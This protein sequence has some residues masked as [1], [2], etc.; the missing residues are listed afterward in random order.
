MVRLLTR[1]VLLQIEIKIKQL[2]LNF[3]HWE[4]EGKEAEISGQEELKKRSA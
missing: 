2:V 4:K 1:Y 3:Q